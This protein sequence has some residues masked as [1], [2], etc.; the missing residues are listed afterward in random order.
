M[1]PTR[2]LVLATVIV[3]SIPAASAVPWGLDRIDQ[4]SLPLDGR[5]DP[6][7]DG[8]GVHAYVIDTGVRRTHQE[9]GGRAD[10]VGDFVSGTSDQPGS[11]DAG[12]CNPAS[13]H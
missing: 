11:S 12:E 6:S 9:F 10:W 7:G 2:T 4:R 13:Q 3:A 8:A 5:F 1:W